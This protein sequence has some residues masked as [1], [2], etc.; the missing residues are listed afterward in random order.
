[1]SINIETICRQTKRVGNKQLMLFTQILRHSLLDAGVDRTILDEVLKSAI[2]DFRSQQVYDHECTEMLKSL[3]TSSNKKEL[4]GIDSIGRILVEYCFFRAQETKLIWPDN[5]DM[6]TQARISFT[7]NVI[8]RPLMQYFLVSVRGAIPQ[9]NKFQAS[10]VLFGEENR[11]HEDRKIYVAELVNEFYKPGSK[12]DIDWDTV[13]NDIRF[14]KIALE[15]IGDIRRKMEQFG[16]ERYLRIL[17]NLRQR[18]PEKQT[19]NAMQRNFTLDDVKLID[20]SLWAAE[21]SLAKIVE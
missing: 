16:L 11:A 6:D 10:S 20:D 14:K 21:S 5:S 18:D 8:P 9:L 2:K 15:L 1:M 19:I 12:T 17:E 13:Y 7:P 3:S 4:R